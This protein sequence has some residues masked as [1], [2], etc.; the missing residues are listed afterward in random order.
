MDIQARIPAALC[1]IHNFTRD[2]DPLLSEDNTPDIDHDFYHRGG[3]FEAEGLGADSEEAVAMR[4]NIAE[5]MW[6]DYQDYIAENDD[7]DEYE[8]EDE[9]DD[10]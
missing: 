4:D 2:H 10:G 9:D 7:D 6:R 1:A 5:Q 8:N 3:P